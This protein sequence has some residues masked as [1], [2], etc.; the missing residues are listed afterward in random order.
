MV[1]CCFSFHCYSPSLFYLIIINIRKSFNQRY[2]Q[3]E[4]LSLLLVTSWVLCCHPYP[5][6]M[7]TQPQWETFHIQDNYCHYYWSCREIVRLSASHGHSTK[8]R[9][10]LWCHCHC[11]W[12]RHAYCA[13]INIHIWWSLKQSE[14]HFINKTSI[15]IIAIIPTYK[16]KH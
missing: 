8:V 10:I 1:F 4:S 16:D 15:A 12:W 13:V 14:K 3:R 11:S 5:Y 2:V 7:V 9:N 6:H